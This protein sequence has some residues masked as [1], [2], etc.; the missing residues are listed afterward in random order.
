[1]SCSRTPPLVVSSL[2]PGRAAF[3]PAC[4]WEKGPSGTTGVV[5][6]PGPAGGQGWSSG[7]GR[8]SGRG[9]VP[10]Y[11][12]AH[13]CP[14]SQGGQPGGLGA[15]AP[16]HRPHT[17]RV[18]M[19]MGGAG[20]GGPG[21]HIWESGWGAGAHLLQ[22]TGGREGSNNSI[23]HSRADTVELPDL[24]PP[25]PLQAGAISCHSSRLLPSTQWCRRK[26]PQTPG[27]AWEGEDAGKCL[28][29]SS[30]L[31]NAPPPAQQN[32]QPPLL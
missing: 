8:C 32:P 31:L 2:F 9:Q 3:S 24:L 11:G 19:G 26:R 16:C 4:R 17:P 21:L 27:T 13:P 25:G 10:T 5:R 20:L 30:P 18:G 15:P 28:D 12:A 23:G 7:R 1:M 22:K 6:S 14:S 29:S